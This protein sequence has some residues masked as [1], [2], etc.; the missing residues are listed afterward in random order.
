MGKEAFPLL[1]QVDPVR[2]QYN[3]CLE[4]SSVVIKTKVLVKAP[5]LEPGIDVLGMLVSSSISPHYSP[6]VPWEDSGKHYLCS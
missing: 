2:P 5:G 4:N 6:I 1:G 3:L